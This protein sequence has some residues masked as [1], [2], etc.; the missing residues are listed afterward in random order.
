MDTGA[1]ASGDDM[2]WRDEV[3]KTAREWLWTP[4]AH[5]AHVKGVGVDCG[6]LLYEV[7]GKHTSYIFPPF[8]EGYSPDWA[9]HKSAPDVYVEFITPFSNQVKAVQPGGFT[10]FLYGRKYS[11]GAIW[12]GKTYIH[13][14]GR[15]G[16][17]CVIESPPSFFLHAHGEKQRAAMHFDIKGE[18]WR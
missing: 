5:R 14:F 18:L 8:P 4:Y 3:I 17:G 16:G 7:Y 6:G 11:H 13:A 9:M 12:T 10:M 1:G 2:S 15:T